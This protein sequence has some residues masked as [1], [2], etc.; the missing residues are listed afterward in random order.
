MNET[1]FTALPGG[2]RNLF[3]TS[4]FAGNNGYWWLAGTDT[5]IHHM[6]NNNNIVGRNTST[7]NGW[8]FCSSYKGLIDFK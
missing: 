7:K 2:N 1:G 5:Y 6:H 3:G 4:D 8:T